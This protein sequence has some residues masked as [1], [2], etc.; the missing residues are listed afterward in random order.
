MTSPSEEIRKDD[1]S[2]SQPLPVD[3][4]GTHERLRN[5]QSEL[6]EYIR[7]PLQN[8]LDSNDRGKPNTLEIIVPEKPKE[9]EPILVVIDHGGG[10]TKDYGGNL[11]RFLTAMKA[12]SEKGKRAGTIGKMGIGML[13][14]T[15]IGKKVIITS[16]DRNPLSG[17]AEMIY[18][19][20]MFIK[21]GLTSFGLTHTKP[22]KQ[23]Y[24]EEFGLHHVGTKVAFFDRE[25]NGEKLD[26]KGI[27]KLLRDQYTVL[28][29]EN[30]NVKTFINGRELELP[31]WMRDHRPRFI[32]RMS[33]EHD[34]RG[35]I[36]K[37]ENGSGDIRLYINGNFVEIYNFEPRQCSGYVNC[38]VLN[39]VTGRTG[40]IKDKMWQEFKAKMLQELAHFPKIAEDPNDE[41]LSR[42]IPELIKMALLPLLPLV[43]TAHG[44]NPNQTKQPKE[45]DPNGT[46]ETAYPVGKDLDPNRTIIIRKPHPRDPRHQRQ[47]GANGTVMSL[48]TSEIMDEHRKQYPDLQSREAR[49]GPDRPLFILYKDRSPAEL[50]INKDNAEHIVFLRAKS[51]DV[52]ISLVTANVAEII[53]EMDEEPRMTLSKARVSAL[54]SMGAYPKITVS[55][56]IRRR[57]EWD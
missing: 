8:A 13:Q 38:D 10:I 34:I 26:E 23:Q 2:E 18:R 17:E 12:T 42:T 9:D 24:Q 50:L 35:N 20:P 46:G 6:L 15:N 44:S 30:P 1:F 54:K 7:E 27:R 52:K 43:P 32:K 53:S 3:T 14:Y 39:T 29:A 19:I 22:A 45:M 33:G 37:D 16:M 21:D 11:E 4:R 55:A 56:Q 49:A 28:M 41:K 48:T 36:W 5:L 47:M 40:L 51:K 31:K 25:P 57:G